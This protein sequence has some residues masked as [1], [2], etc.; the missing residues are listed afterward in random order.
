MQ[1][2]LIERIGRDPRYLRLVG[3]RSRLAWTLTAIVLAAFFGFTLLIA[4]DKELLAAPIASGV[5]SLGIPLG[6]GMILLAIA[7]TGIY[8]VAANGE[9]DRLT[10]EIVQE[11]AA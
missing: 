9:F 4:F 11:V 8:V 5:T 7:L 6:F 10:R 3:R 1:A 2:E